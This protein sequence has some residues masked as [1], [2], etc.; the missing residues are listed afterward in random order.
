MDN[1]PRCCP[2][3]G[4]EIADYKTRLRVAKFASEG[5]DV[6]HLAESVSFEPA[7]ETEPHVI[8]ISTIS[9]PIK[10]ALALCVPIMAGSATAFQYGAISGPLASIIMIGS[11]SALML[12]L[13]G[14]PNVLQG[15]AKR[16]EI[17][18]AQ[19]AE[20]PV[21]FEPDMD[22]VTRPY[23]HSMTIRFYEPP[24]RPSGV[25]VSWESICYACRQALNGR[26]FSEREIAGPKGAK[27]SGPDFRILAAD[28]LRR[29]YTERSP[30]GKTGF[31]DRGRIQVKKLAVLPY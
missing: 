3:C 26:P 5:I 27:I 25:P 12:W 13:G 4:R 22:E 15:T 8:L 7:Q 29:R 14:N 19:V 18:P 28:F 16:I 10:V 30:D 31:T 23:P 24:L 11:F 1:I 6:S 21:E 9:G 2:T 20:A 17:Q